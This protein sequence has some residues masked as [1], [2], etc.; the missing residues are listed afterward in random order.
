[1]LKSMTFRTTLVAIACAICMSAH[2]MADTP[3]KVDIPAGD[4]RQALLQLSKQYGAD[5]VYRPEQ[6]TGLK[7]HGAHGELTTKQ[8]VSLLLEGTPLELRTDP[9]GAMLIAP[10][11]T[12][13]LKQGEGSG[14]PPDGP[15]SSKSSS[16]DGLRLA[17]ANQG[18]TSSPS[19]VETPQEKSEKRED[20]QEVNVHIPEI[21]VTGSRL[22]YMDIRRTPDDPQPY[23]VFDRQQ[24]TQSGAASL[25]D[26]LKYRL[27]MNAVAG[28]NA[29]T[30]LGGF[31]GNQSQINLR[32]L[33]TNQTLI[34]IDGHRT[35]SVNALGTPQQFDIN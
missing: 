3:K 1:M 21:L 8:A 28:T 12:L 25:E 33:G 27:T 22:L 2:A 34:L 30:D 19:T 17:Q 29:Q 26:F 6:V 31:S 15:N 35:A 14:D 23:V 24:I 4:L 13:S 20:L 18:Q 11:H 10:A 9:S 16:G 32:G 5:L 7:T